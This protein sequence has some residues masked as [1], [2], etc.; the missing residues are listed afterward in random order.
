MITQ[1]E[2]AIMNEGVTSMR[3]VNGP[4]LLLELQIGQEK[5]DPNPGLE[6]RFLLLGV[7]D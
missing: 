6:A 2:K 1:K 7:E 5:A 3:I 4:E